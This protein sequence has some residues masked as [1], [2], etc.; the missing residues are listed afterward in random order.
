MK[1]LSNIFKGLKPNVTTTTTPISSQAIYVSNAQ[2]WDPSTHP[3]GRG[4]SQLVQ[5]IDYNKDDG[6]TVTYRDGFTANYD[7][8]S[9]DEA[10]QFAQASSKGKWALSHL[11]GKPYK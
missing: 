3:D 11:W 10:K 5:D 6:L 9:P 8:I 7:N 1:W 2:S 4:D